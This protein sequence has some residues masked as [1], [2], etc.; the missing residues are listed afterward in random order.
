MNNIEL[1]AALSQ[2]SVLQEQL[3]LVLTSNKNYNAILEISC[4]NIFKLK[5]LLD[6][7]QI[8]RY[9]AYLNTKVKEIEEGNY[10]L[11]NLTNKQK[12]FIKKIFQPA[13]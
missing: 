5:T 1:E 8:A 11:I 4:D 3:N 2:K 6:D 10:V 7:E 12:S 9:N 13:I